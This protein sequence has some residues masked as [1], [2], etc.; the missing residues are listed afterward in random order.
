VKKLKDEFQQI[1]FNNDNNYQKPEYEIVDPIERH[2]RGKTRTHVFSLEAGEYYKLIPEDDF[3]QEDDVCFYK[4]N[5]DFYTAGLISYFDDGEIFLHNISSNVI[6]LD[7]GVVV[8]QIETVEFE[9]DE[10]YV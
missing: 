5:H 2:L 8:G 9:E 6:Y 1:Y 3:T 10:E 4:P 7:Q